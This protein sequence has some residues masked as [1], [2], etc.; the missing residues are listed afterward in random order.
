M[1]LY[2]VDHAR[3]Q[4]AQYH[5]GRRD[6]KMDA[7]RREGQPEVGRVSGPDRVRSLLQRELYWASDLGSRAHGPLR[8]LRRRLQDLTDT[9]RADL[10][11]P[12]PAGDPQLEAGS[13]WRRTLKR[14]LY[15]V[16]RP[17]TRRHDRVASELAAM[18]LE[19]VDHL[20]RVEMDLRR[21]DEEVLRLGGGMGI[22]AEPSPEETA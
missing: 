4:G 21:L 3:G 12:F 10:S 2:R 8:D 16:L 22:E 15:R 5:T 6:G 14:L 11:R 13:G 1:L 19:V 7:H 17:F 20:A 18:S 9:L